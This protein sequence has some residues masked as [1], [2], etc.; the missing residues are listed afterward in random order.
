[1][2]CI[3][4]IPNTDP[5]VGSSV[6]SLMRT[7]SCCG[8][9]CLALNNNVKDDDGTYNDGSDNGPPLRDGEDGGNAEQAAQGDDGGNAADAETN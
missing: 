2:C 7:G 6:I 9:K 4:P 5:G 3:N 8:T 1:M